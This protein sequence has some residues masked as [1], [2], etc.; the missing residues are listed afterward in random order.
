MRVLLDECVDAR[1]AP[2]IVG[3]QARTVHD[4][5]W[6][7]IT[8]GKLLALAQQDFDVFITVDRDL[9]FQQHLPKYGLAVILIQSRS[10]RLADLLPFV[11]RL[12]DTIPIAGKGV[13]TVVGIQQNTAA[14]AQCSYS[15]HL[16]SCLTIRW[17]ARVRD[18]VPGTNT[19]APVAELER[20]ASGA[21]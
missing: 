5:G 14:H 2:Y 16:W 17:S 9:T 10:N 3:Y 8:N 11:P 12:V 1:L 18:K 13:V 20:Q 15:Q 4:Q 7:G 19:C 21:T 6:G